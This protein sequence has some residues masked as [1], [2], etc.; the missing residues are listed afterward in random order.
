MV[1]K[2]HICKKHWTH[3][4]N[5]QKYANQLKKKGYEARVF[6]IAPKHWK[7]EYR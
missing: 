6:N 1:K 7:V 4:E 3:K 5:A 2:I